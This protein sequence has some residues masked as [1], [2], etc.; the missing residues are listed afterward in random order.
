MVQNAVSTRRRGMVLMIVLALLAMVSLT[1]VTFLLT[2][3]QLRDAAEQN[4]QMGGAT[5]DPDA[6]LHET[7]MQVIRG[8]DN[9]SS[10]IHG[11]S[12]LEDMYGVTSPRTIDTASVSNE[13]AV[14]GMIEVNL[15]VD[16]SRYAGR[17]LTCVDPDS[18]TY[19]K[20]TVILKNEGNVCYCLPFPDGS[21]FDRNSKKFMIN[22]MPFQDI[23][24]YDAVDENNYFLTRR[25]AE[26]GRIDTANTSFR[27]GAKNYGMA[28]ADNDGY[29]DSYWL[30]LGSP[31]F[32]S[33]NGTLFKPL[34]GIIVED[35]DGRLNVN[36]HGDCIPISRLGKSLGMGRGPGEVGLEVLDPVFGGGNVSDRLV[37]GRFTADRDSASVSPTPDR[38]AGSNDKGGWYVNFDE[39]TLSGSQVQRMPY[40]IRGILKLSVGTGAEP[41]WTSSVGSFQQLSNTALSPNPYDL[42]LGMGHVSGIYST[43]G[44]RPS[45]QKDMPYSP[46]E[47]EALLRPFDFD[48]PF[49]PNRLRRN[50]VGNGSLSAS[51]MAYARTLVTTESWDIPVIP[52]EVVN[53]LRDHAGE[54]SSVR[55]VLAGWPL[56][57]LRAATFNDVNDPIQGNGRFK[58]R[59]EFAKCLYLILQSAS[60]NANMGEGDENRARNNA[61]WAVN[62]VDFLDADSVM[63]PFNYDGSN[64]VYGCERPE[65]LLV[66]S[67]AV[68][69]IN[70]E[71]DVR[72]DDSNGYVGGKS[73][74]RKNDRDTDIY[75]DDK[76]NGS[77]LKNEVRDTHLEQA[78]NKLSELNDHGVGPDG[79]RDFDQ[80]VRPQGALFVEI[81][82]P[83]KGSDR[84]PTISDDLY[85]NG[86]QNVDLTKQIGN[87]SVWRLVVMDGSIGED[88]DARDETDPE[89]NS[90]K[91]ERVINFAP[92]VSATEG[93]AANHAAKSGS[94]VSL[95]GGEYVLI[96]PEGTTVLSFTDPGETAVSEVMAAD[97]LRTIDMTSRKVD[98]VDYTG[99]HMLE[100]ADDGDARMSL[101]EDRNTNYPNFNR[102]TLQLDK[103][104]DK[105]LDNDRGLRPQ[106]GRVVH[107]Q[108]L[109]NPNRDHDA[110]TNPYVTID[111]ISVDLE[112]INART[113]K[114]DSEFQGTL[115]SGEIVT[116]KRGKTVSES[117]AHNIWKQTHDKT[118]SGNGNSG[119]G[120]YSKRIDQNFGAG[121]TMSE[122]VPW[123][124]WVNRPPVSPLELMNV[125]F[126]RSSELLRKVEFGETDGDAGLKRYGYL[127]DF[128]GNNRKIL[129]CVRVPSPQTVTPM[130]LNR[131]NMPNAGAGTTDSLPFAYYSMYREPG[132]INVN[133]I[134]DQ[135]VLAALLNLNATEVSSVWT[136]FQNARN[137][138]PFRS[139]AQLP[140]SSVLRD[141]SL[142]Q[143]TGA[144]S[145]DP[146]TSEENHPFFRLKDAYR[147]GNLTTTRSNVFA[148][149]VTMGFFEVDGNGNIVTDGNGPVELGEQTGEVRR[150]RAFYLID[151]S[152]PVGFERGKNHNAEDVILLKRMLQ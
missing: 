107:L 38:T 47:L 63:T 115:T 33:E 112:I 114:R 25:N 126:C 13:N 122:S 92:G 43:S 136:N 85:T 4:R 142:F 128:D 34:F 57:L 81:F 74:K 69:S 150:Y 48:S 9:T 94:S 66:E 141:F 40:D 65:L 127:P 88:S 99:Q 148:V 139:I 125:T 37:K 71:Y 54:L 30:D 89:W 56:D 31:N 55:E 50:L 118:A 109:A 132:R 124:G 26:T 49:L 108:R 143:G 123:L 129:G 146:G 36:A 22:E 73:G 39:G 90:A 45:A 17:V 133:T 110:S 12:L 29:H 131:A 100:I 52:N 35:M 11:N 6:M 64:W 82:N 95:A 80:L 79:K 23:R 24:D 60:I 20:S 53:D 137:N 5:V 75:E 149:W 19:G 111:T 105:P 32:M 138:K 130:V 86:T 72:D 41:V 21:G 102:T 104:L 98:G 96:G 113:S 27:N 151:R 84:F 120:G 46:S 2:T 116:H 152:I 61:Q 147:L 117:G 44:S 14:N 3:E 10:P 58:K 101:T 7:V 15:G 68:H 97:Q 83:W 93:S 119:G 28:D 87:S 76:Q 103:P 16:A 145:A 121:V 8:T 18:R 134:Y 70:S 91:I 106:E 67:M 78:K 77:N 42:D 59:E 62:V 135:N 51:Q 140:E 144:V 1:A